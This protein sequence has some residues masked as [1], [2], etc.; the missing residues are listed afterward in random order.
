MDYRTLLRHAGLPE[1]EVERI[2]AAAEADDAASDK[3]SPHAH[4]ISEREMPDD[5]QAQ[6]DAADRRVEWENGIEK[7]IKLIARQ[8]GVE[9][10]DNFPVSID[11]DDEVTIKVDTGSGMPLSHL[12]HFANK[13]AASGLGSDVQIHGSSDLFIGITFKLV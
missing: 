13:L 12:L 8:T 11:S 10:W 6:L 3:A 1:T 2:A 9:L 4:S 7:N 5:E